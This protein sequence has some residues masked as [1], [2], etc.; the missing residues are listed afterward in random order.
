MSNLFSV[1]NLKQWVNDNRHLLKP[2]VGNKCI[3][4]NGEYIAMVIGGPNSRKDYHLN[5]T[6]EFY[7]QVEGDIV[8]KIIDNGEAKDIHINEGDVYLLPSNVPH[9]PQRGPGTIGLVIETKRP[10][11]ME[12]GLVWFCENCGTELY[13]EDFHVSNIETDLPVIF[14]K[15]YKNN[16]LLKCGKCG[17]EMKP[18]K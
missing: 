12:D 3:W 9:S 2:P 8:L 14:D 18:P 11:D 4:E 15:F 5:K 7:Y 10:T 6:P 17:V 1:V 13:Q 16:E